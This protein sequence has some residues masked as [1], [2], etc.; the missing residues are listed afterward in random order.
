MSTL[1]IQNNAKP[2]IKWAGGKSQILNDIRAQ[3]PRELGRGIKKYAE[4]FVGGGAVLFDILNRFDMEEVYISDINRE[5]I[6][7]YTSIK[8]DVASLIASLKALEETYLHAD[9]AQRKEIYY[10]NRD[11]FNMLKQHNDISVELASLFIFLNRTCFNGLY[12]VNSKGGYNVPQGNYKN[13]C[14][15]DVQNLHA[16]SDKLQ[17]VIITHADYQHSRNFIDRDTFCYFDPPYRPLTETANFNAYAQDGFDDNAQAN[18]AQ[19]IDEMSEC[20]AHV[21]ASNSDPT[22]VDLNDNFFDALYARHRIFRIEANRA[23]NS[24]GSGRG[25][26]RELLIANG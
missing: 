9:D 17:R 19:F 24:V 11:R 23:I 26:I 13:P 16:V 7:S 12:R 3:Y 8:N 5:L 14:I 4:P 1:H 15:C 2:F 20:G 25:K 10:I 21:V 18:L 6:H 22:N